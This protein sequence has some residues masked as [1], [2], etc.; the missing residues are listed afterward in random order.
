MLQNAAAQVAVP[1]M[2]NAVNVLHSIEMWRRISLHVLEDCNQI[3]PLLSANTAL[4][5]GLILNPYSEMSI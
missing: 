5:I 1:D 4:S 2:E 3:L